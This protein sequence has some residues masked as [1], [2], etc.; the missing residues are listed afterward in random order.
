MAGQ[1]RAR[2]V[3]EGG[4]SKRSSDGSSTTVRRAK[5]SSKRRHSWICNVF[6]GSTGVLVLKNLPG[7]P[8]R[9]V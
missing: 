9:R 4:S 7:L 6:D 8:L 1:P 3:D 5:V 2:R